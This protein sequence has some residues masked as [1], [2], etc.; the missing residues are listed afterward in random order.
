MS[1]LRI[2]AVGEGMVE[3]SQCPE[4]GWTLGHGGDV[5]NTA[6]HLARMGWSTGLG[7]AIGTGPFSQRLRSG[8]IAEGLDCSS[9]IVDPDREAGLYAISLDETGERSFSYWRDQSA[10]RRMFNLAGSDRLI[11]AIESCN[12]LYFSLITL[13]ILS[14]EGRAELL[15][16]AEAVKARDGQVVFDGN[17]R[18]RLWPTRD[19][20]LAARDAAV[21]VSTI[22]LPTLEDELALGG[23]N[24]AAQVTAN[25]RA[26]GC[27]ECV[28]KLGSDGCLL[29]DGAQSTPAQT[30]QPVDTSG[31]GDAFSAGYLSARL[32]GAKPA[33]AAQRGHALAGWTIMRTGAIPGRDGAAPYT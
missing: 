29:P 30:L 32:R 33:A 22:G 27:S 6:V 4:G 1:D 12:V 11:R 31:A 18:A 2:L 19:E 10:A 5:V 16:H 14:E 25:W 28:V 13:A 15:R 17:Y 3:L 8:W 24:D 20:A 26:L 9:V 23:S 7:S 21:A